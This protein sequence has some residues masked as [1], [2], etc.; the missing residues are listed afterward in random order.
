MARVTIKD[1][2]DRA[3]PLDI[4]TQPN[5]DAISERMTEDVVTETNRSRSPDHRGAVGGYTKKVLEKNKA[6]LQ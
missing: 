5:V 6:K 2:I 1:E 4:L 3:I